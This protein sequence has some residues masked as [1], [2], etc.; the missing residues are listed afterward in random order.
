MN[1]GPTGPDATPTVQDDVRLIVSGN[2]SQDA[3]GPDRYREIL[4]RLAAAPLEYLAAFRAL[5]QGMDAGRLSSLHL[6]WF[7]TVLA[8][9]EPVAARGAAT[10]LLRAYEKAVQEVDTTQHG[11]ERASTENAQPAGKLARREAPV[12]EHDKLKD[13]LQS[14]HAELQTILQ[15]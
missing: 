5:V 14:R 15:S 12:T 1:S 4:A 7:L 13:R 2:F 9:T 6:P 10:E 8:R 11:A 3:L